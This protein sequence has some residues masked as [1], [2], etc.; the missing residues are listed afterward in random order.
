MQ[1]KFLTTSQIETA[2]MQALAGY[3]ARFECIH[4]PIPVDQILECYFDQGFSFENLLQYGPDTLGA[5]WVQERRVAVSEDLDPTRFPEKE[6]RYRFTV[7][8]ELGHVDLHAHQFMNDQ[9][10]LFDESG[11]PTIICRSSGKKLP[12][13]WQADTYAS[14]LLMPAE[15]VRAYWRELFGDMPYYAAEEIASLSRRF[16]TSK[17]TLPVARDMADHF[18]VSGQAM[19]IR[20]EN[21]GLIKNKAPEAELF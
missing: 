3:R 9:G 20:L 15:M 12:I 10:S 18:A 11:K 14:Y 7:G 13:E 19:Q 16:N 17:P 1:V 5:T 6:G 4:P 2:A 8:H 21:I